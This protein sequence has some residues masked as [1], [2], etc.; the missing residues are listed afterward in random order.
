M[1]LKTIEEEQHNLPQVQGDAVAA[2]QSGD[3]VA[4]A[5][6][7]DLD[8]EKL[9]ALID[10][11]NEQ[12]NREAK[13]VFDDAF[14]RMQAEFEPVKRSKQADR[15]KY[16]TIEAMQMQFDDIIHRHGFVY[17]W[18]EEQQQDGGIVIT[19]TISGHGHSKSNSKHLPAY[20]VMKGS[21]GKAIMNPLQAE[22]VRSSYGRRY[23]FIAG[24]GITVRDEDT[25]GR[26][27]TGDDVQKISPA[28]YEIKA[29]KDAEDLKTVFFAAYNNTKDPALRKL[30]TEAKDA[31][32]KELAG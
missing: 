1:T 8:I 16:A 6:D 19:L 15:Y 20:E 11:R 27:L 32:K 13:R 31:R 30:L 3:L 21:S 25:D 7:R 22:G 28:I 14:S 5:I 9:R 26:A 10:M 4:M 24:F 2:A 18:D 29:A 23:T 17:W 12:E